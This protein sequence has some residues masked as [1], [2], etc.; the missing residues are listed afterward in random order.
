MNRWI[1]L[2][3]LSIEFAPGLSAQNI[4]AKATLRGH[5]NGVCALAFTSDGKTLVSAGRDGTALVHDIAANQVQL[6]VNCN[7]KNTQTAAV[8][9]DGRLAAFGTAKEQC[10]TIVRFTKKSKQRNGGAFQLLPTLQIT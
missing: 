2:V 7:F 1:L 3:L 5:T 10:L 9:P 4:K 8:T 6:A